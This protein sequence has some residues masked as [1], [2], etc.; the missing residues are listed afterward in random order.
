MF[1]VGKKY[2]DKGGNL[3]ECLGV[4][5]FR[6]NSVSGVMRY[7]GRTDNPNDLGDIPHVK[8]WS[9]E[10]K[11]YHEPV[12]VK[13]KRNILF[14]GETVWTNHTTITKDRHFI[15]EVEFTVTD[16]KLTDVRIV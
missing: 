13:V 2:K 7:V 10:W 5:L 16:G 8:A 12:V 4:H 1:E 3:Y 11:E 6:T 9:S 14:D 15:N